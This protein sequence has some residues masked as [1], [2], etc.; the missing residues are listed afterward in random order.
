LSRA[1]VDPSIDNPAYYRLVEEERQHYF[2]TTGTGNSLDVGYPIPLG[3]IM[4]S[5]RYWV[6]E[7]HVDGFR[8]DLATTL[9]RQSGK[10]DVHSAFLNLCHQDPVLAPVKLIAEPWGTAGYQVGGFLAHLEGRRPR[11]VPQGVSVGPGQTAVREPKR[12][13]GRGVRACARSGPGPGAVRRRRWRH[14]CGRSPPAG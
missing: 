6:S 10:Q 7:M 14:R 11:T 8:F 5:L 2:D 13:L 12:S 4:D 9:T 3:L 1:S